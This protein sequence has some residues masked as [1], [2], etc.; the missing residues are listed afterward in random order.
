MSTIVRFEPEHM[1]QV[2]A[3]LSPRHRAAFAATCCERL[4]PNYTAFAKDAQWG[5]PSVL[6]NALRYAWQVIET[7]TIDAGRVAQ[8]ISD[9]EAVTPHTESFTS[10]LV[11]AALDAGVAVAETLRILLDAD[12]QRAV[13][14]ASSSRDTIDMFIQERDHLDF[15]SDPRF[16]EKILR[17]GLMQNELTRQDAILRALQNET[18]L[19]RFFIRR[20]RAEAQNGGFSNIGISAQ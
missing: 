9:C 4:L 3:E 16:E 19:D 15:N 18:V 6:Q 1:K 17:D 2:L 11:S 14:V 13:D 12:P 10:R 7:G 8:M 5:D 20:L